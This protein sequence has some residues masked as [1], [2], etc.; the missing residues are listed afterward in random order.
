MALG[1]PIRRDDREESSPLVSA[2][3]GYISTHY[4]QP[5]SLDGLAQQFYVS[6]YH[7]SHEF[8]RVVGTSVYR[9]I[10]LKR[11][12]NARQMLSCGVS[13]G[14]VSQACGF[15]DYANFYRAFRAQYGISPKDCSH[16]T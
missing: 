1:V 9:Y 6:K 5:L 12:L 13:P 4:N 15:G 10:M 3:L 2:V 11:L 7:L 16:Q 14:V 8:S